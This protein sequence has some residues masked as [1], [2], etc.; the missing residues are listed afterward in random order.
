MTVSSSSTCMTGSS[1]CDWL[2]SGFVRSELTPSRCARD[3]S[4][5]CKHD[6]TSSSAMRTSGSRNASAM[7]WPK[8][9]SIC[10]SDLP[11]NT[12]PR[13]ACTR[14]R[15]SEDTSSANSIWRLNTWP[16]SVTSTT[17]ARYALSE[18]SESCLMCRF[19]TDGASTMERQS[20]R[21]VRADDVCSKSASSSLALRRSSSTT[22]R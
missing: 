6:S 20:V 16:S 8:P 11:V 22:G 13:N 15:S 18:M 19:S 10:W 1:A 21:R 17:S 3:S 4:L 14:A 12:S 2:N 9:S 5:S 7:P